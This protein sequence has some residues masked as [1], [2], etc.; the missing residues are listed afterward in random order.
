VLALA[1]SFAYSPVRVDFRLPW[2]GML[3]PLFDGPAGIE[4][5]KKTAKTPE[6]TPNAA[7]AYRNRWSGPN[8]SSHNPGPLASRTVAGKRP[9]GC[10]TTPKGLTAAQVEVTVTSV[11][12]EV[13]QEYT[14]YGVPLLKT[15]SYCTRVAANA[16]SGSRWGKESRYRTGRKRL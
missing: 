1:V 5:A 9:D 8:L 4:T 14:I 13:K 12:A 15:P 2:G 10:A 3:L 11:P 7:G 6:I 16:Q